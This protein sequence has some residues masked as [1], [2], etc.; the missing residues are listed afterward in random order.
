MY[1]LDHVFFFSAAVQRPLSSCA[2]AAPAALA[3]VYTHAMQCAVQTVQLNVEV[4]S[5]VTG[6]TPAMLYCIALHSSALLRDSIVRLCTTL[7]IVQLL[8]HAK[9][10]VLP[11]QK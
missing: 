2:A 3:C 4:P 9:V 8:E 7:S 11:A 1:L 6:A 5:S 10:G